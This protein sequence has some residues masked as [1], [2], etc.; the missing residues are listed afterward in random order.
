MQ[1]TVNVLAIAISAVVHWKAGQTRPAV[2]VKKEISKSMTMRTVKQT[3]LI[4]V[5]GLL[6]HKK[7]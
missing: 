6:H 1:Q 3:L 2:A 5:K 7:R 4:A